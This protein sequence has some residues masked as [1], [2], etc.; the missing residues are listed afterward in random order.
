MLP[1]SRELATT[2]S[3]FLHKN[4]DPLMF[5]TVRLLTVEAPKLTLAL[6][7]TYEEYV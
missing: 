3:E 2:V 1:F 6:G 5:S 7:R 4:I